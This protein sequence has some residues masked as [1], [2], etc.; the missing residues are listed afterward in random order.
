VRACVCVCVRARAR[1]RA[2]THV[3]VFVHTDTVV[4]VMEVR[5]QH[6]GIG[7]LLPPCGSKALSSGIPA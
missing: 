7:F 4:C 5:G 3:Y 1:A 2:C 6:V